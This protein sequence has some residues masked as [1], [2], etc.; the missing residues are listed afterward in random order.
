MSKSS[1]DID[2]DNDHLL[3]DR[4]PNKMRKSMVGLCV[5]I[6]ITMTAAVAIFLIFFNSDG[7]YNCSSEEYWAV[8][9]MENISINSNI[10]LRY[11]SM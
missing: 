9:D 1:L 11:V 3:G 4:Q 7:S 6:V 10:P 2:T 8:V 5:C